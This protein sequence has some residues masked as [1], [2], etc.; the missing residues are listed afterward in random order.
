MLIGLDQKEKD[1]KTAMQAAGADMSVVKE[2]LKVYEKTRKL[3]LTIAGNYYDVRNNL[4]KLLE[5]VV[6]LEEFLRAGA[7]ISQQQEQQIREIIKFMKKHRGL[8]DSEFLISKADKDFYTT[9]DAII[10]L[11]AK[12]LDNGENGILL[13][14]E[15][16]NLIALIQEG[17]GREKPDLF[18]LSYFYIRRSDKELEELTFPEK[19]AKVTRIYQ[20]EFIGQIQCQ[21]V[22]S[23]RQ[24]D[25][26][27]AQCAG[28]S[29]R[30]S[31][32]ILRDLK[33]LIVM[34]EDSISP[35]SRAELLLKNMCAL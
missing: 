5:N 26:L 1:F 10:M 23:M 6:Q 29:D 15:I 24:S 28:R 3:S 11:A 32:K 13:Q 17:L 25:L 22:V 35:E 8:F 19:V 34:G 16:E 4:T 27:R 30:K 12:F 9:F 20:T 21:I 33:P 31:E 14:S 18:A 7:Q 2:W